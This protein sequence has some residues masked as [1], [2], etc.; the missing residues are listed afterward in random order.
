MS[1]RERSSLLFIIQ[2]TTLEFYEFIF[3]QTQNLH[4]V[5]YQNLFISLWKNK[6]K[7]NLNKEVTYL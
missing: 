6:S 5:N 2:D 4:L 7:S 1:K 3:E